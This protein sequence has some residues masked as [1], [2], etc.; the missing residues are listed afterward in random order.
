MINIVLCGGSGTRLWPLS[1]TMLPKQFVRLFEGQSLFQQ[2]LQR[3]APLCDSA[4][5]VS[6]REQYFLAVD[7]LS[8]IEMQDNKFLLEPV[9]RNTAP[10][11]TLACLSLDKETILYLSPPRII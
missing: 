11:I 3:N 10:A 5:I 1:R 4:M 9:G 2:T 6:N 8:Q 7:Q